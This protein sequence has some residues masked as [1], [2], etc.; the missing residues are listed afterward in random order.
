MTIAKTHE[1][2]CRKDIDASGTYDLLVGWIDSTHV[3]TG[4]VR[5]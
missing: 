5:A 3:R 1:T 2:G 4:A